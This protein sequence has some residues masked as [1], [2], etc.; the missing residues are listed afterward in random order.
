MH[1]AERFVHAKQYSSDVIMNLHLEAFGYCFSMH[2]GG[3]GG[4]ILKANVSQGCQKVA[5]GSPK[6]DGTQKIWQVT[7]QKADLARRSGQKMSQ[8]S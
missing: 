7:C 2:Q 1:I 5:K 8:K 4:N 3:G 6:T